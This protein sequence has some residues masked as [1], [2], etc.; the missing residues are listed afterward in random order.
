MPQKMN[1]TPMESFPP[2]E[3]WDDW[4]EYDAAAWPKKKEKRYT[5]VPTTCFNCE[6]ACG[7]MAYVDKETLEI[8]R[9]DVNPHH[10]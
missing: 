5:L 2:I 1:V 8:R 10:A 3:E 6:A 7:L 4:M 9:F